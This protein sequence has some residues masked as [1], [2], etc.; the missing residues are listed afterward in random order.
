[1]AIATTRKRLRETPMTAHVVPRSNAESTFINQFEAQ[2]ELSS[3]PERANAFKRFAEKGLPT[4]RVESW[5]YTDLRAAM[6]DAAPLAPS[7]DRT[8]IETARRTLAGRKKL[9]QRGWFCST[10]ASSRT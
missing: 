2:R 8:A 3:S 5:H 6:I 1:M 4:R 7:P 10:G 9:E